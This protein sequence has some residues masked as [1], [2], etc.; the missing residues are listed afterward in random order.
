MKHDRIRKAAG[1]LLV[2]V[3][4]GFVGFLL[5]Q[6]L[7][8]GEFTQG[9]TR[10]PTPEENSVAGALGVGVTITFADGS[11]KKVSPENLT[12]QIFPF[13]VYF[14][15][16]EVSSIRWHTFVY[17]DWEGDLTSLEISGPMEVTCVETGQLLRR[18]GML[19]QY[20]GSTAPKG[21]WVDF[22]SFELEAEEIEYDLSVYGS[23]DYTLRCTS[24]VTAEAVFASGIQDS[25]SVSAY[26]NLPISLTTSG[27]SVL[28]VD[29][30]PQ[31]FT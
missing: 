6:A 10:I 2:L 23:G 20:T 25:K 26:A 7:S 21:Q 28:E 3:V 29:V 14:Q 22:W 4:V 1:I 9:T 5:Y 11:M 16:Q 12:L 13:A 8:Q 18:E 15:G 30:Q 31:V 27:L 19:R 17:V 24:S